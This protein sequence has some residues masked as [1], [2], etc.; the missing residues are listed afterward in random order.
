[1]NCHAFVDMDGILTNFVKGVCQKFDKQNPYYPENKLP[2]EF[3]FGQFLGIPD[4]EIINGMDRNDWTGLEWMD[5]GRFIL[6]RIEG[7]FSQENVFLL[8]NPSGSAESVIGKMEWIKKHLPEYYK[9]AHYW[10]GGAKYGCALPGGILFDDFNGNVDRFRKRSGH[11]IM[12]P[13]PWNRKH[14]VNPTDH[15]L[16]QLELL[17]KQWPQLGN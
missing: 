1:M 11:A 5:D 7:M 13:R 8:S 12:I 14:A 15:L 10:I 9:S 3:F 4:E 6:D 16:T 2:G 17:R